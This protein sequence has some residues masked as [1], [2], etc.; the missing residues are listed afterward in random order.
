MLHTLGTPPTSAGG[1]QVARAGKVFDAAG[2]LVDEGVREQ[3]KK[4]LAGFCEFVAAT[5]TA[6]P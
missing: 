5:R 4:Y 1:S 6:K 2:K 3:L